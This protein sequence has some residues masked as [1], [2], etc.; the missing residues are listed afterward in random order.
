M[1]SAISTLGTNIPALVFAG[2]FILLLIYAVK[3]GVISF[4][5]HGLQVGNTA[6]NEAKIRNM[7]LVYA[8]S[9]FESTAND[10]PQTCE[11]YHKMYVISQ[12]LDEVER[13]I[14]ENHISS[15]E[16]YIETEFQIIYN[17]V[18]KYTTID[19]FR[20]D[21]FQVYLRNLITKLVRQLE[22]IRKQYS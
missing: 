18:L 13:M 22:S 21:G 17:I 6:D 5:G 19:Y 12:C 1:W 20:A 7:Q 11:F 8:K 4:K 15:D 3:K 16:T 9:L 10:M 2:L 14:R